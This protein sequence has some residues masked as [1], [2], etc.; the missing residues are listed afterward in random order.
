M[1]TQII[2]NNLYQIAFIPNEV[3]AWNTHNIYVFLQ[4][5]DPQR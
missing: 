1:G 3:I 4:P 5:T 2:L